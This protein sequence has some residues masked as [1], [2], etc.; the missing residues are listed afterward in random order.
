MKNRVV[1]MAALCALAV[2]HGMSAS[3]AVGCGDGVLSG[4]EECD[5][6]P[7]GFFVDGD[8][9]AA[10]CTTGSRCYFRNTCCKFN[11]QYVGT[12]G[13]PCQDGDNCSGPDACNQVGQC[14]GGP[15]AANDTPC[16]DGL[17][18]TG[19]E[20]CQNGVCTSSSGDPCPGTACN[21]CQEDTDTCVD[22]AGSACSDGS[23][24]VTG[25]TC[26]GAGA[27]VGGTFNAGPCDDGLYCNGADTCLAGACAVHS[28]D[29][30]AGPDGDANCL[31]SCNESTD[32]CNAADLDGSA[33][34]DGLF[35]NGAA[36]TCTSGICSGTG[37]LACDDGNS[38]T[39][40]SCNELLDSCTP[41]GTFPD[42]TGCDDGDAC[43]RGD[44]C[45]AGACIGTDTALADLCPWT[46]VIAE[47]ERKD[48]IRS[49]F[50]TNVTGDVC[51]G[52][53]K[54][55]SETHVT[56]DVV[57]DEAQG[58]RQVQ[59]ASDVLIDDD[60][61]SAGAGAAAN[62]T[63]GYLPYLDPPQQT[64][65]PLSLTAKQ[66]G[67]GS[68]DLTGNHPL[69]V[70]C[71]AARTAYPFY[72][73]DLDGLASTQ[74]HG[75]IDMGP[76]DTLSVTAAQPGSLNVIDVDGSIKVGSGGVLTLDGGGS[77]DTVVVLRV[78]GRL[79]LYVSS[80]L[81]LGGGLTPQ[82]TLIYVKGKKCLLNTQSIG[83]GTLFASA[84]RVIAKQGAA[85]VGAVYGAG[86]LLSTGQESSFYYAP[87][88][89]F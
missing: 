36:D 51:G 31:E 58:T 69:V 49:Y 50:K 34:D 1:W 62:P 56:G 4:G 65:A 63:I 66:G 75:R 59:L 30:C 3:A 44:I 33:C 88:Q 84:G 32:L 60:I 85:W 46:V 80:A 9:A 35:C 42:G 15:A 74:T 64:L 71:Q 23:V 72:A 10:T 87:F 73:G 14:I 81:E 5:G 19:T 12:P 78:S 2:L 43:T 18:C 77:A 55:Y 86:T 26:D 39:T 28:G 13:V 68:Y 16:D 83:A 24:C 67:S 54:F 11:C 47:Q 48:L 22:S 37:T 38:C 61:V 76:L 25:G 21:H 20:S 52:T 41:L 53:I 40:E 57:A 17:F 6:G 70:E 27:C 82:H 8:P 89:G 29:P 7:V 45:S 79:K